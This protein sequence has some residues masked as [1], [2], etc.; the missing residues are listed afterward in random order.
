VCIFPTVGYTLKTVQSAATHSVSLVSSWQSGGGVSSAALRA[1]HR[2]AWRRHC[3]QAPCLEVW[4]AWRQLRLFWFRLVLRLLGL[5]LRLLRQ[6]PFLEGSVNGGSCRGL[7]PPLF[8]L[9]LLVRV[10]SFDAHL[11]TFPALRV[12]APAFDAI[13]THYP[14]HAWQV[15]G[16]LDELGSRLRCELV[17]MV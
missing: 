16:R 12:D 8:D 2:R 15:A 6:L 13:A 4:H 9:G 3:S 14:R 7:L 1:W 17:K 11:N 5:R 10:K